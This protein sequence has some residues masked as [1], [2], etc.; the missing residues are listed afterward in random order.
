MSYFS[1]LCQLQLSISQN[2]HVWL[3]PCFVGVHHIFMFKILPPPQMSPNNR[4]WGSLRIVSTI[5]KIQVA[6]FQIFNVSKYPLGIMS[7]GICMKYQISNFKKVTWVAHDSNL[8]SGDQSGSMDSHVVH[9]MY[10]IIC[11]RF[12]DRY[13]KCQMLVTFTI[14]SLILPVAKM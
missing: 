7:H 1:S 4:K 6:W 14:R 13:C 10:L 5:C 12:W 11:S 9:A 8:I 2:R 3:V